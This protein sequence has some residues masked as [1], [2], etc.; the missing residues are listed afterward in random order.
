MTWQ[1]AGQM[2]EMCSCKFLCP[3]WFGPAEP[4]QGWCSGA[5]VFD[6]ER[7]NADGLDLGAHTVVLVADWPGDFWEGNGTARLYLDE[8]A[9][10]QQRQALEAIF[11]GQ[12]GGPMEAV[13]AA[14]ISTWLPAQTMAIE[15]SW[16]DT[17]TGHVGEV[18][19]F[20]SQRVKNDAGQ[21]A[22]IQGAAAMGA[23]QL[24]KLEVAHTA[25]SHWANP[26]MRRWEAD[27]GTTGAFAW[28]A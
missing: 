19:Q 21:A 7:G 12:K 11:N 18:A 13:S 22:T 26:E 9:T 6:V 20:T 5:I 3:C 14:V 10:P 4:D 23:F 1:V 15:V 17:T 16:G 24:E 28:S 2:H 25:G 8:R 27:S